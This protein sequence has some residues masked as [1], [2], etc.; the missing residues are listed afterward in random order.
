MYKYLGLFFFISLMYS[1]AFAQKDDVLFTVNKAPVTVN[2][3]K[4][5]YEKSNNKSAD[6][7]EKSLK[8]SLDLYIRFKLKVAKAREL[9]MDTLPSLKSELNSYKQQLADSYLMDKEVNER[10]ATEL[11]NRMKTDVRVAHIFIADNHVDSI[12]AMMKINEIKTRLK[13]G[14]KFEDLAKLYSED[15]SSKN[16]GGDLGFLAPMYPNGFY[17]SLGYSLGTRRDGSGTDTHQD[18]KN[19]R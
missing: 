12:K 6:Y 5:I 14:D 17:Q 9:K 18:F 10:L 3:F 19:G 13:N 1:S 7:S 16:A 4:Y 8:E 2:E 15:E 11:F